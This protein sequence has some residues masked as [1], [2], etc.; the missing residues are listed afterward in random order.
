MNSDY[1]K[2]EKSYSFGIL[3]GISTS[4]DSFTHLKELEIS[5][6]NNKKD[7]I[8]RF[9]VN[10]TVLIERQYVNGVQEGLSVEYYRGPQHQ[11]KR[12]DS[13]V[14]GKPVAGACFDKFGNEKPYEPNVLT[15]A[16]RMPAPGYDLM[17][18]MSNNLT[19]PA[20]ARDSNIQGRVVVKFIVN[21]DG[22]LSDFTIL[23]G[24]GG[25]CNET[26][27]ELFRKMPPWIPG[28]QDGIARKVYFTL[29]L[30]FKLEGRR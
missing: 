9:F 10:D 18:Y 25:G 27:V 12:V 19:Y 6:H 4:F 1:I 11:I 16:E 17:S 22:T 15:Y 29:P 14:A 28:M 5:Y 7:G 23:Q 20:A 21:E 26:T 24:V 2:S 30:N 8:S 3:D 13:F